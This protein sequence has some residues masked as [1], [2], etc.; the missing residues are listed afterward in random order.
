M[1]NPGDIDY[2]IVHA[3]CPDGFMAKTIA[4]NYLTTN[5]PDKEIIYYEAQV[6]SEPPDDIN[7]RNV[8]ICDI[9]FKKDKILDMIKKTS[10]LLIIDHH[11]TNQN[12]LSSILNKY[13]I[14]DMNYSASMLVWKYFYPNIDHEP[15]LLVKYIEDHDIWNKKL[16]LTNEFSAWFHKLPFEIE[17]YQK[18]MNNNELFI[19]D[20]KSYGIIHLGVDEY[21]LKRIIPKAF[22]KFTKIDNKYYFVAYINSNILKSEIG[23]K[24]F[25]EYPYIDF[26]AV[27]TIN[28]NDD[29]TIFSLRSVKTAADVG[30]IAKSLSPNAGGHRNAA[31]IKINYVCNQ[32]GSTS[33]F[34]NIYNIIFDN[35]YFDEI[36]IDSNTTK[37]INIVYI[38]SNI[39]K[40][41]LAAY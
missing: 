34:N 35:I 33:N 7:N 41:E 38:S 26:S 28:D 11:E 3:K 19:Q 24:L 39:L 10:N 14:F 20:L 9:S 29:S 1:L 32:L 30:N 25:E 16:D 12:D 18:Y 17:I 5:H 2:V 4:Y 8:L 23:S 13:K 15:P 27:Y 37:K 22:V 31:G 6:N 21:Y 36:N 40:Y